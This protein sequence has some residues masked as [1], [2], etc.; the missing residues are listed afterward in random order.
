[1]IHALFRLIGSHSPRGVLCLLTTESQAAKQAICE[2][3]LK[4]V[5]PQQYAKYFPPATEEE[6]EE[7]G[8]SEDEREQY[9]DGA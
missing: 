8:D 1:M 9:V 5:V 3:V 2:M 7:E 4:D 6:E